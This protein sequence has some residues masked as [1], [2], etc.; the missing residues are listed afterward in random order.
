MP[1]VR[2][3]NSPI[4]REKSTPAAAFGAVPPQS[5]PP[6]VFHS[7]GLSRR[8]NRTC[9]VRTKTRSTA[10]FFS[11]RSSKASAQRDF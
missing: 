3:R 5:M 11:L 4:D 2:N 7:P 6:V 10:T 8:T 1:A 9:V